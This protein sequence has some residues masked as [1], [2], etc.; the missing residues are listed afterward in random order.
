MKTLCINLGYYDDGC[1]RYKCGRCKG[2]VEMRCKPKFCC[3]CG[4]EYSEVIKYSTNVRWKLALIKKHGGKYPEFYCEHI[5]THRRYPEDVLALREAGYLTKCAAKSERWLQVF[6]DGKWEEYSEYEDY[7]PET[8]LR[9]KI[10]TRA[11][12]K[13]DQGRP[14]SWHQGMANVTYFI[15]CESRAVV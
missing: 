15:A 12:K 4:A 13:D 2:A 1:D 3:L 6:V 10:N 9:W 14:S 8:P 7:E 5:E 11:F